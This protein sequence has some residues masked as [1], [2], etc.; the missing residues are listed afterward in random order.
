DSFIH[1]GFT[2]AINPNYPETSVTWMVQESQD[3]FWVGTDS[4]GILL[5][6]MQGRL[7][8][9]IGR[10]VDDDTALNDDVIEGFYDDGNII[11]VATSGGGVGKYIRDRKK[12]YSFTYDPLDPAGLH[13]ER[14]LQIRDDSKGNLWIATWTEGLSYYDTQQK[15]FRVY[16]HDPQDSGSLSDN[17]IMDILVDRNDNLWV[18]SASTTL[19]LLRNGASSFEHIEAN[20]GD[21]LALQSEYLTTMLEDGEG[22][23]WLGSRANGLFKLDPLTLEFQTFREPGVNNVNLGNISYY[24]MFEDSRG[25]LWLGAES[26]GLIA[27][28]REKQ[29]LIQFKSIPGDPQ[30]L[31]NDDVMC[32]HEDNDGYIWLGTYGGGLT[33]F[34]P[35][36]Q[37]F[38]NFGIEHGL[39]SEAIYKIFEDKKGYLWVS[40]NNG[41][42][43]F[44]KI[45]KSFKTYSIADGV[46][47]KEFN[48][49]GC[50]DEHGWLYFG[51][52][53]GITYFDPDQIKDNQYIP[54]IQFT[55]LSIMNHDIQVNELYNDRIVLNLSI[56]ER[57]QITLFPEDLFFS[58]SFA[59]LDYYHSPSNEYAYLMEGLADTWHNIGTQGNITF[60]NLKPGDYTLHVKGSNNDGLWNEE[61]NS[62]RI[63]VLP[64]FYETWWFISGAVLFL[65]LGI[66]Q[67][68]RM[69]TA[70]LVRHAEELKQHNIELNAQIASRRK[71]HRRARERADYFRAVISRSPIPMAIH[72]IDGNITFLNQGWVDLW[73]SGTAED[74]I[75]DYQV[76]L[77]PLSQQLGLGKSFHKALDGNILEHPEVTFTAADGAARMVHILLYPLK[78][79]AGS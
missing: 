35:L 28:D 8:E 21:S 2:S 58:I 19:D 26:E 60:T 39:L 38:E 4:K 46:R 1:H 70:F 59:S 41:L 37:T 22:N 6:D 30:A 11:W 47:S 44:D 34:D 67:I 31:P 79:E 15:S 51:G 12:F 65:G 71:A 36:N 64:E 16:M 54:P 73:K 24:S 23:I 14:I 10:K 62:L 25:M 29:S 13:D 32:F 57:P 9:I 69:R 40:T 3:R 42:A 74:I 27:F 56:V 33:K 5:M 48:P 63:L 53:R 61:G 43:R 66:F 55:S 72:N 77:D 17:G 7:L 52:V 45:R 75:R 18:I 20:I 50:I 76:D 78:E 49:A 68:S